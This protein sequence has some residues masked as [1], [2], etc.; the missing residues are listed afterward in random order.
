M[1]EL[2]GKKVKTVKK[3]LG[4][5]V[6]LFV[7]VMF[8]QNCTIYKTS[9]MTLDQAVQTESKV[10][11]KTTNGKN[12]ILRRIDFENRKYFGV[13]KAKGEII[14]IPLS[15]ET[16]ISIKE[17]DEG[18]STIGT[19]IIGAILGAVILIGIALATY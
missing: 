1:R 11:V 5:T 14:K 12:L 15:E 7:L 17:K 19:I 4:L 16:I 8:L 18:L 10:N 2:R 9:F 13:K 3:H 6:L